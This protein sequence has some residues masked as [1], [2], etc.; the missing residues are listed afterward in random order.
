MPWASRMA[1]AVSSDC[2]RAQ[3]DSRSNMPLAVACVG[4]PKKRPPA[5]HL[6][7]NVSAAASAASVFPTPI[8]A[9]R[10]SRPGSSMAAAVS[11]TACCTALA[12]KPKRS[13]KAPPSIGSGETVCQGAGRCTF[14]QPSLTRRGVLAA[15]QVVL[16]EQREKPRVRRDPVRHDEQARQE[17]LLRDAQCGQVCDGRKAGAAQG[18]I[19]DVL[20]EGAP[21][22]LIFPAIV[23]LAMQ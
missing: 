19:E 3:A 10:I 4:R 6:A 21:Q 12:A 7:A 9:S 17:K 18:F 11:S 1:C 16:G 5:P 2:V 23:I 13:R 20:P 8:C 15:A 22:A 14:A